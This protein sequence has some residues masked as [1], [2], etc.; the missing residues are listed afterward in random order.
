MSD[1][2]AE[3]TDEQL[4]VAIEHATRD[5]RWRVW[6]SRLREHAVQLSLI[7]DL[8][9]EPVARCADGVD[10][11]DDDRRT[12]SRARHSLTEDVIDLLC[13]GYSVR[14]CARKLG[15]SPKTLDS[16]LASL[17]DGRECAD[18]QHQASR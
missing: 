12:I 15:I 3:W 6:Q 16:K 2:V 10:L 7:T 5:A 17:R 11:S 9:L 14:E 4:R 18:C 1:I 8:A 13:S